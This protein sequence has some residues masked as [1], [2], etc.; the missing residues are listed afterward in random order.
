MRSGTGF[1]YAEYAVTD[2][3]HIYIADVCSK[4][5]RRSRANAS[6]VISPTGVSTELVFEIDIF[7]RKSPCRKATSFPRS[8]RGMTRFVVKRAISLRCTGFQKTAQR[9]SQH[10]HRGVRRHQYTVR[11]SADRIFFDEE[12]MLY[13]ESKAGT[14]SCATF[15]QVLAGS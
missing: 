12:R 10:R 8:D 15:P 7:R 14:S 3:D 9:R 13:S 11:P 6:S 5:A 4:A 2:G 1:Y